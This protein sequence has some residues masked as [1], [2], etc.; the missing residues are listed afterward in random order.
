[1][2]SVVKQVLIDKLGVLSQSPRQSEVGE[3]RDQNKR[4][5][6][7]TESKNCNVVW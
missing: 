1:M 2:K 7:T 6:R 5:R 4:L 3:M